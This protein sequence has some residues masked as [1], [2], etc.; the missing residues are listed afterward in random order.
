MY[1]I[2]MYIMTADRSV[3]SKYDFATNYLSNLIMNSLAF[4]DPSSYIIRYCGMEIRVHI[5]D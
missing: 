5:N 1:I 3:I 2:Y 4:S